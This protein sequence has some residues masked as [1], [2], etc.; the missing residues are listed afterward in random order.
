MHAFLAAALSE[1]ATEIHFEPSDSEVRV[2]NRVNGQLVEHARLPRG[3]S[4][5]ALFWLQT[6]T[7][8][9]ARACR[10]GSAERQNRSR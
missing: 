1:E 8:S 10:D 4:G 3:V 9:A 7:D 6:I 5:P 2:R